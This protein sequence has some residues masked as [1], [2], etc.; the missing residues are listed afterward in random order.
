MKKL[1]TLL[2]VAL[3]SAI[4]YAQDEYD[5]SA[6]TCVVSG[7]SNL[8]SGYWT[9]E[10]AMT[11]DAKDGL[12]KITLSAKDTE[13][14]EFKIVYDGGWYGQEGGEANYKFQ[15][16]E[17]SDV[18]ITFDPN[19][20]KAT[21]SGPK[22]KE[23]G[24]TLAD[25]KFI[26][27]AGS[28]GLL[29][30]LDWKIDEEEAAANKMTAEDAGYYTLE[31]KGIAAGTYEFK[32]VANGSWSAAQWG[33]FEGEEALVN[34]ESKG[35]TTDNGKNFK[36]SLDKG[37]VYDVTLTLDIMDFSKPAVTAEWVKTGDAVITED[38]YSLAG[39]FNDWDKDD[40]G[41]ELTKV[42]EGVY[43]FTRPA[44]AGT[45]EF[46]IVKNHDW[47][48]AYPADNYVL[49]L[50]KDADVTISLDITGEPTVKVT[51]AECSV[52][53]VAV[54]VKTSKDK[55]KVFAC[56]SDSWN[57]LTGGWP[58][59]GMEEVK[60]FGFVTKEDLLLPK[61]EK[62]WLIFNDGEGGDGHQT[63]NIEVNGIASSTTLEYI[64]NDDWSI[65]AGTGI[66]SVEMAQKADAIY[67]LAGQRV[68]KAVRGLYIV[69]GKKVVV[70]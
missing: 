4:G 59:E 57:Q 29:N 48:V 1:F 2:C 15:V 7:T 46:K 17:P 43:S 14:I 56:Y 10:D 9:S 68:E 26:V 49:T 16:E 12:W 22:V 5:P 23:Y 18:D 69:N 64:L 60:N 21:Y 42:S 67:N 28:A 34:G 61:G 25:V 3:V 36:I 32:F 24:F 51:T 52:Y 31:L 50:E 13:A 54:K 6:H 45:Y 66:Q 35:A 44:K 11:Y 27:A 8:C 19:T 58:G 38:V 47:S 41:A 40:E 30:G 20:N 65:A 63:A 53:F 39:T 70:R 33:A 62:L 37:A 55:L